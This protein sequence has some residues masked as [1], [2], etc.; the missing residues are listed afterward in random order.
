M[1]VAGF[2]GCCVLAGV[3]TVVDADTTG[4]TNAGAAAPLGNP[5]G[6]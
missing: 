5:S 4:A 6:G 2:A 3:A 1:H